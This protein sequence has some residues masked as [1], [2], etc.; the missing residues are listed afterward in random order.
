MYLEKDFKGAMESFQDLSTFV[1]HHRTWKNQ[2]KAEGRKIENI[3][4]IPPS[5]AVLGH[6]IAKIAEN[7]R[8]VCSLPNTK[9]YS[10]LYLL[11]ICKSN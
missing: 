11:L 4:Q 2:A 6:V 5:I 9:L 1:E 8:Q 7:Q 10:L 3:P